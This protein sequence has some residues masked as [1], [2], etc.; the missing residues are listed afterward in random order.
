MYSNLS[1]KHVNLMH[2]GLAKV[3]FR[4]DSGN[5]VDILFVVATIQK[6]LSNK[7]VRWNV[8]MT[9]SDTQPTDKA[10]DIL[11]QK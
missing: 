11:I 4:P 9:P 6:Y 5:P 1:S 2:F 10:T 3:V 8:S 7:R